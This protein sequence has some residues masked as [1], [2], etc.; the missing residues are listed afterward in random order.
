MLVSAVQQPESAICIYIS[1]L[2]LAS[3]SPQPPSNPSRSSQSLYTLILSYS[4]SSRKCGWE[5]FCP[6]ELWANLGL[7]P[8]QLTPCLTGSSPPGCQAPLSLWKDFPWEGIFLFYLR[9]TVLW[10]TLGLVQWGGK[11]A[12]HNLWKNN[13]AQEH[14]RNWLES[15]GS[16]MASKWTSARPWSSVCI[17]C[18]TS[19]S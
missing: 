10:N 6:T 9:I 4:S 7:H 3:L 1:P 16:K 14:N 12:Q 13:I 11:G 5:G 15:N 19:A 17:H 18:N 8:S 2:S